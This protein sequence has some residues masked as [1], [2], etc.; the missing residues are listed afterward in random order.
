MTALSNVMLQTVPREKAGPRTGAR[1]AFQVHVSLTKILELHEAGI[2]YRVLFD[3]FDDLGVL[4]NSDNPAGVEFFQIKGRE[5]GSWTAKNLCVVS[6]KK[7]KT[8]IGKMYHHTEAFAERLTAA[9]FITNAAF[10]FALAS[11]K[12]STPDHVF[13]PYGD[14]APNDQAVFAAALEIDYPSPRA[15]DE[16]A[17][18]RFERTRVPILGYDTYVKGRLVEYFG[19]H[20]GV[21]V[22]ALYRT[23]IADITA[24]SNNTT[25]CTTVATLHAHK[26]LSRGD[27]ETVFSE[28][29]KH[30]SILDDWV[31]VDAQLD[32]AGRSYVARLRLRT[33]IVEYMRNRSK[34]MPYAIELRSGM[35]L[36][37]ASVACDL[38]QAQSLLDAADL[39][40]AHATPE[41][42][43]KQGEPQWEAALFVEAFDI[44]NG[45]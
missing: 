24:K 41:V 25:E 29:T 7:P 17:I 23:L 10:D 15:P 9:V 20:T 42:R 32:A 30:R 19:E 26:S 5:S 3:Y 11:G 13:I 8:I 14:I 39:I 16:C 36:A 38:A 44:L 2:D 18:I 40:T 6:G 33:A 27:L 21:P 37:A 4:V 45:Q 28:A 35:R 1:F 22:N 43:A 34:R 12:K 31:A